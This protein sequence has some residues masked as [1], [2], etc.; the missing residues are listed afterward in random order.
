MAIPSLE[1]QF[2]SQKQGIYDRIFR[3]Q[4]T[5]SPFGD[6]SSKKNH[7]FTL[8]FNFVA[9]CTL[10]VYLYNILE[11]LSFSSI[12]FIV[13]LI[14]HPFSHPSKAKRRKV[15]ALLKLQNSIVS[16]NCPFYPNYNTI[17]IHPIMKRYWPI[18]KISSRH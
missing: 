1:N 3:F 7:W 9:F 8:G 14:I 6:F 5:M 2:F 15:R 17:G 18:I 16:R 13:H 12:C 10:Y 11:C 4:K